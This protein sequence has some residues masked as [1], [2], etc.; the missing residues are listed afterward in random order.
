MVTD[1]ALAIGYRT[2][3]PFSPLVVALLQPTLS[4]TSKRMDERKRSANGE[5][6]NEQWILDSLVMYL[7]GPIWNMPILNF[8]EEKSVSKLWSDTFKIALEFFQLSKSILKNFKYV[9]DLRELLEYSPFFNWGNSFEKFFILVRFHAPNIAGFVQDAVDCLK[10]L[11]GLFDRFTWNFQCYLPFNLW[12]RS[13]WDSV[14]FVP[15]RYWKFI[16]ICVCV[17]VWKY[18]RAARISKTNT[19]AS[20]TNSG[21]W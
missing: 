15:R 11:T 2:V 5:D 4:D 6:E 13:L 16:I 10:I 21:T 8:I 20:T 3:G 18:L 1:A 12:P 9:R 17:C 19:G 14:P 7:R